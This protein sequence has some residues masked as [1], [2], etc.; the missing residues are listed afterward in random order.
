MISFHVQIDAMNVYS[1]V[2]LL[3]MILNKLTYPADI[4]RVLETLF[5]VY[6]LK[7]ET[8]QD[9]IDKFHFSYTNFFI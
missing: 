3:L 7:I 8:N 5:T 6:T 2:K 9:L 1:N 4:L